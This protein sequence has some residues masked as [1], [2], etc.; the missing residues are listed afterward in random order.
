MR[1][2][3]TRFLC[4]LIVLCASA[5]RAQLNVPT[6]NCDAQGS[7]II[8]VAG[9]A[10]LPPFLS[11]LAPLLA[12]ESPPWTIV[13]Q[14]L[15]SCPSA[16]AIF[17]ETKAITD[18]AAVP[19]KPL[20]DG[21]MSAA[22]AANYAVFFKPDGT[23]QEC[24]VPDGGVVPHVGSSDV[25]AATCGLVDAG[26]PVGNYEGPIVTYVFVVPAAST[27]TSISAEAAYEVFGMGGNKG[28]AAPWTDPSLLLI[29]NPKAGT[30]QLIAKAINVPVEKWWG[31]DRVS[32][33]LMNKA[34]KAL[35]DPATAEKA[36][37]I[38]Q[39]EFSDDARGNYRVLA[40]KSTGQSCGYLPDSNVLS[41]DKK[42]VREGRYAMWG[43]LHLYARTT[44]NLPSAAAAALVTRFTAQRMDLALLNAV[45]KK[46]EVPRCAMHVDRDT[47]M[48]TV[49]PY[50]PDGA[51]SC[52]FEFMAT[53]SSTCKPCSIL[54]DCTADHPACN[55]GFCE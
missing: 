24:W 2:V 50:K 25:F 51:C 26:A 45:I 7:N 49:F 44:N 36:I 14:N 10:G 29:R 22:V 40:F 39:T 55:Y 21:G 12:A 48:G 4:A 5:A 11:V 16:T 34:L 13:Y 32:N 54:A 15:G 3:A 27:Q 47:E 38:L 33:D 8:Y 6:V 30:Q 35:T 31:V 19:P 18:K 43:P 9:T 53:G 23:S 17:N 28:T 42:N 37:G 20:A 41:F 46:H 52:Y 1:P